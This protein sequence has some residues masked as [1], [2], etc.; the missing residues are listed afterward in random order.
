MIANITDI[1]LWKM[2]KA[3]SI[4]VGSVGLGLV[5]A[6]SIPAYFSIYTKVRPHKG[7]TSHDPK[8]FYEDGD[9]VA[10][11]DSQKDFSTIVQRSLFLAS[12]VIGFL[13]SIAVSILHTQDSNGALVIES[14]LTFTAWVGNSHSGKKKRIMY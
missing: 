5:A 14:W 9:G 10:T 2:S 11:E 13:L 7:H 1:Q 3:S 4:V 6:I 12:S 8:V